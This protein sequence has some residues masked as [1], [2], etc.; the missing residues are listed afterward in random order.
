MEMETMETRTCLNCQTECDGHFCPNCGQSLDVRRFT[1]S[2]FGL[3]MLSA[4]TR[5]SGNFLRTAWGLLRHPW[6]VVRDYVYGRRVGLVSPVSMLLL[7]ALYWGIVMA[8]IPHFSQTE[9]LEAMQLGGLLKWL[10]GSITFQYLFLAIPIA[11][12]TWMVYRKDMRSR[13]NFAELLIATL[14]LAC[15]FLLVD[16]VLSPLI[17]VS[18]TVA[19]SLIVAI[20]AVYGIISIIKA[21]PQ[22]TKMRT[23]V[24]LS[25]WGVTC[26]VLTFVFLMLFAF[27][28]Y[29]DLL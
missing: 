27:P 3:H 19:N 12:G 22:A 8:V 1:L 14:Y 18:D 10:Y 20:T 13:F 15:T 4:L 29:K 11:S 2:S 21:F 5:M 9:Q 24:K 23:T 28:M 17:L 6:A 7:L 25:L 26:G 16:F